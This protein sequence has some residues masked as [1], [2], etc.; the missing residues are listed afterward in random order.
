[1][2]RL[3]GRLAVG[4]GRDDEDDVLARFQPAVAVD[5]ER[6]IDGPAAERL[7]LDVGQAFSVMPG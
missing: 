1:M 6:G 7:G 5:D 2:A 4:R 3:E